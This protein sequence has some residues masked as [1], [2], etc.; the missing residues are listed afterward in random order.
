MRHL[1]NLMSAG[2]LALAPVLLVLAWYGYP[3]SC[4]I[5]TAAFASDVLDGFLTRQF[6]S[7]STLG[8]TPDSASDFVLYFILPL[9]AW[10]L[11]PA[12]VR[13]ASPFF[14]TVLACCILLPLV[15]FG[16]FHSVTSIT[17]G[18]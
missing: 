5:L 16:K 2:R 9:G 14:L 1:P 13:R 11:W 15:A 8:A 17:R 12:L 3:H 18:A 4:L 6:G 10:W 7:T